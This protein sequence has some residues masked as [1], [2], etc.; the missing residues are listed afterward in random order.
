M[1]GRLA[2]PAWWTAWPGCPQTSPHLGLGGGDH[3]GGGVEAAQERRQLVALCSG[4]MGGSGDAVMRGERALEGGSQ[5]QAQAR[6]HAPW[7]P[8]RSTLF[9]M[10]VFANSICEQNEGQSPWVLAHAVQK[11]T[12][13]RPRSPPAPARPAFPH[14]TG[15]PPGP[16]A[17]RRCCARR[18]R[19]QGPPGPG[20]GGSVARAWWRLQPSFSCAAC[21]PRLPVP[22]T[23]R[24]RLN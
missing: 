9:K 21:P 20:M 4:A 5:R 2:L 11:S 3:A 18:P 23:H 7:A 14:L 12:V 22:G 17:G 8:T 10:I 6:R 1:R 15:P 13:L 19:P 16:A 24:H